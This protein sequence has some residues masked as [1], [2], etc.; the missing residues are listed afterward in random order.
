MNII[1]LTSSEK[2]IFELLK[3]C[4]E[5]LP[6]SP[7]LELRVVG[8]WVRD[9]VLGRDSKDIDIAIRNMELDSFI[10]C[11]KDFLGRNQVPVKGFGNIKKDESKGKNV[12]ITTFRLEDIWLDFVELRTD[13][14]IQ[15]QSQLLKLKGLPGLLGG[16]SPTSLLVQDAH[17]RDSTLN[18]LFFNLDSEVIED[19][20]QRGLDDL[21]KGVIVP[22]LGFEV[23]FFDDPLRVLRSVRF[24][25]KY[26]FKLESSL[27]QKVRSSEDLRLSFVQ[28]ISRERVGREI[29]GCFT[30]FVSGGSSAK[31]LGTLLHLKYFSPV[32]LGELDSS[33]GPSHPL[34]QSR[35]DLF[36]EFAIFED[37]PITWSGL[38][39]L[40]LSLE[41]SFSSSGCHLLVK[42]I[43]DQKAQKNPIN[44][45]KGVS[46][47]PHKHIFGSVYLGFCLL[48]FASHANLPLNKWYLYKT[49]KSKL[50]ISNK[51]VMFALEIQSIM[52]K[53]KQIVNQIRSHFT[54]E[55][56]FELGMLVRHVGVFYP[57]FISLTTAAKM[58][59]VEEKEL[60]LKIIEEKC[61]LQALAKKPFFNGLELRQKYKLK[62]KEIKDALNY[63]DKWMILNPEKTIDEFM[64]DLYN[65]INT[66]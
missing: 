12:S 66:K 55:V 9:K 41:Q 36:R 47:C 65:L 3:R 6:C 23:S 56:T 49:L 33:F 31:L 19:W 58:V 38:A 22:P 18:S 54:D 60:L 45:L 61:I 40:V 28:N 46:K 35:N 51:F 14:R 7:A 43:E 59:T 2:R 52:L 32:F 21:E 4:R 26:G 57:D 24:M 62:G 13:A 37:A 44:F 10:H 63:Q 39:N 5:G 20:T 27:F 29:E 30:L 25:M 15:S 34:V 53:I 1:K 17:L 64:E 48:P 42:K 8:G 11:F 50:K 16:D